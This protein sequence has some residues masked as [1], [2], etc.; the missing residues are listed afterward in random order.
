MP[1]LRDQYRQ[2]NVNDTRTVHVT[3]F[4]SLTNVDSIAGTAEKD[5]TVVPLGSVVV[6]DIAASEI[7][8]NLGDA[9]GWLATVADADVGFWYLRYVITFAD[10]TVK[11]VPD[12][13]AGD[14]VEVTPN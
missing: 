6:S 11:M 2:G 5:G 12:D 13:P 4:D 10:G 9:N 14:R 8:A 1:K 7:R 3:G